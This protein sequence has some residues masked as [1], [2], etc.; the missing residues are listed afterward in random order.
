MQVA[1]P[2]LRADDE[3]RWRRILARCAGLLAAV[4]AGASLVF[5]VAANWSRMTQD[6]RLAGVQ[7]TL[8]L[9]VVLAAGLARRGNPAAEPMAGLAALATGALLAL[10]GQ[11]Y[12]TGADAWELFLAWAVLILPWLAAIRSVFLVLLWAALLNLSLWLFLNGSAPF[13][14]WRWNVSALPGAWLLG[15]DGIL[16]AL[17]EC[18]RPAWRD[19]R[20]LI[21][22][23]L[24]AATLAWAVAVAAQ[25]AVLDG[26]GDAGLLALGLVP[27]LAVYGV[28]ARWRPDPAVAALAL[29]AGIGVAGFVLAPR[30]DSLEGLL[31]LA[32]LVLALGLWAIRHALR[33]RAAV[34]PA[35]EAGPA[36]AARDGRADAAPASP[37]SRAD[38]DDAPWYVTALRIGILIPVVLLLGIW[39]ALSFELD[40]AAEV[41]GAGWLLMLPGLWLGRSAPRALWREAGGVLA[42]L[43]L[44]LC[45][46]GAAWLMEENGARAL[47]LSILLAAGVVAY[48]GTRRFVVRLA[49]AGLTLSLGC[50]LTLPPDFLF[51]WSGGPDGAWAAGLAWRLAVLLALGAAAWIGSLAAAR[52]ALWRPLAW[53]AMTTAS[54]L[55]AL[56]SFEAQAPFG[57]WPLWDRGALLACA[58][59]PGVLLGAWMAANRP[60]LPAG[61]RLGAPVAC[62]AAGLGWVGAPVCSVALVG[63]VLGGWS[64]DRLARALSVLLGLA[65]L[66]LYYFDP[67]DTLVAKAGTLGLTAAWLAALAL[68][69]WSPWSRTVVPAVPAARRARGLPVWLLAGGALVLGA[70]QVRVHHYEAILAQGRPVVIALAPVDPR[71]LMQGDYMAL[72]YAVRRQA[73]DWLRGQ[74]T[75]WD[76]LGA[77]GRG[78][79]L[80]RPDDRGVWQLTAVTAEAPE[81]PTGDAV[82]LAFRW[83]A[84]G[85]DWGARSWFFPE[86]QGERYAKARYG[87]LRVA[88]D[89]T[90]L[91]AGL[92]DEG[93]APL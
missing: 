50:W 5:W 87:V 3:T 15:L 68:W 74:D 85:M 31:G 22:R 37:E 70:V 78:W 32:L 67:S 82:A 13:A 77:A 24:A 56:L 45:A 33:L 20:G 29:L 27:V 64:G 18:L 30:A 65:G 73:Q 11:I 79:L 1:E 8:A 66:A 16:L 91:L 80:L 53:A 17:A 84:D 12:Q 44:L 49:A 4:L 90:A 2:R 14:W 21:R 34:S 6:V 92:L 81:A 71:S 54:I 69:S 72:D 7:G 89:G 76:A 59:L 58:L 61:L 28:Y 51:R 48:A 10:V 83:R 9:L 25:G 57:A 46:G 86:G 23:V 60:V 19:P 41:L 62:C 39:V 26:A 36:P 40:S 47:C 88:A 43:G 93:R 35:V 52:R 75:V 42:V 38:E 55:A 63:F